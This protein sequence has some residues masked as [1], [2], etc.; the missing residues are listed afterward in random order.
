VP[1]NKTTLTNYGLGLGLR[2]SLTQETLEFHSSAEN[3]GLLEWLEIVPENYIALGGT[4]AKQFQQILDSTI[5]LIPHG[6]NLSIGTAPEF[7][8]QPC[9]DAFLIQEMHKLFS[10]INPPWFSDH[11]S[12]TRINGYYMQD[13]IPL[14][15][16]QETVNVVSDNVKFLQDEFQLPFLVENPSFYSTLI[17]PEMSEAEFINA[18]VKKADCGILLDVNNIYVNATNHD[19]YNPIAFLDELDLDRVVQVHIAGHLEGYES[20]TGKQIKILDTHGDTI[21]QEVYSILDELLKRTSV[22]AILLER[23]S[24]FP[25]FTELVEELKEI[26]RI[27]NQYDSTLRHTTRD[28]QLPLR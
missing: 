1:F 4:K 26:R 27:M 8:G 21:K 14:P 6:V 24:N 28:F 9:F 17:E 18:I 15:F 12:C 23:D 16:T 20:R 10:Q 13:L 7:S 2:R 19:F 22:N 5:P 25:N 3:Q 11:L